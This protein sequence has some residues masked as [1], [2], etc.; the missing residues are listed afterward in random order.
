MNRSLLRVLHKA[1]EVSVSATPC[2]LCNLLLQVRRHA[3]TDSLT[4]PLHTPAEAREGVLAGHGEERQHAKKVGVV[5]GRELG[6][7]VDH[8]LDEDGVE[9]GRREEEGEEGD[10][11]GRGSRGNVEESPPVGVVDGTVSEAEEVTVQP[12]C[13]ELDVLDGD[14]EIG[15]VVLHGVVHHALQANLRAVREEREKPALDRHAQHRHTPDLLQQLSLL[16]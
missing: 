13:V 11:V 10:V 3:T 15:E 8:D 9:G 5:G 7:A 12:E 2:F 6:E 4:R 1:D 16:L 14:G